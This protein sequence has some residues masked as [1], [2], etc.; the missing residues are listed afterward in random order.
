MASAAGFVVRLSSERWEIFES[1][2][3]DGFSEPVPDF[4]HSR[5]LPLI[6]FIVDGETRLTHISL[7]RKGNRAGTEL[8]RLNLEDVTPLT[9]G[10][11]VNQ[12]V[13]KTPKRFEKKV[14]EKL[15]EGGLLPPRTFETLIDVL[16]ELD[17]EVAA[18]LARYSEARRKRIA[19]LSEPAKASL[20]EQKEAIATAMAIAGIDRRELQGWD[21]GGGAEITSYLDGLDQVRLREDPMVVNDLSTLPGY[22]AVKSTPFSSVVFENDESRLTVLLANRLELE[23]LLGVDLIYFNETFSCFLMV[24]YKAMEK[25]GGDDIY[26]FPNEQLTEELNRM[27]DV[28]AELRKCSANNEADGFRLSENPFFLKVCPRI[29]FNPDNISLVKG[30][31]LPLEYWELIA[32]HPGLVGPKGGKR[33]SY[34]NVR[35]YFDNTEFITIA[36]G[37]WVGTN[38]DQSSILETAIRST[39]RSGRAAVIAINVD[40]DTRHKTID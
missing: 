15:T 18:V 40:K 24:Q 12:V 6:C 10:V 1:N 26:R 31:Y 2:I 8:Q 16:S 14:R 39:L 9:T 35:R 19:R 27:N 36:S 34:R 7:G 38:I 28:L 11:T 21:V 29:V 30:M 33:L 25:E 3:Y 5:S 17:P 20:A 22:E 32:D 23:K 4:S 13:R 37:A